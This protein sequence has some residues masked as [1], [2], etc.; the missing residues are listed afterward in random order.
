MCSPKAMRGPSVVRDIRQMTLVFSGDGVIIRLNPEGAL[1]TSEF[2]ESGDR[3]TA[4]YSIL[5]IISVLVFT[6]LF[7]LSA[8]LLSPFNPSGR[9]VHWFARWWARTLL[10]V[11]RVPVRLEGLDNLPGG[12]PCVLVSNH[13]SAADIPILFGS[14]PIQFRIIAKD[15]LFHIPV[16]G[17]CM[18]LAGYISINRTNPKK[19]MRSL[20]KAARQIREGFPAVVFPE[21]TRTRTGELQPF[22]AGAFMLAIESGVPVVPVGISGSYDILVRGSMKIRPDARVSVRIGRH[23]ATEGY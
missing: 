2:H 22:K 8:M 6:L 10:W 15:S 20:K 18:R 4:A 17:W 16:L 3:V 1:L 13:A 12:Q 19:A 9:L 14:L 7:G 21:G 5:Q 11:G 23:I